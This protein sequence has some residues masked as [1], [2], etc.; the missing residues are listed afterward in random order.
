MTDSRKA[1][2]GCDSGQSLAILPV[3]LLWVFC[4][5]PSLCNASDGGAQL[6]GSTAHHEFSADDF[7]WREMVPY[8][9]AASALPGEQGIQAVLENSNVLRAYV[10]NEVRTECRPE[11]KNSTGICLVVNEVWSLDP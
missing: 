3:L 11:K 1:L 7:D 10:A 8:L 2:G 9:F 6:P 5:I 4:L